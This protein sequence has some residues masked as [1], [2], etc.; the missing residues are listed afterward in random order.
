MSGPL[1]W[2]R[3]RRD[4]L[5]RDA[6][7][8]LVY[9]VGDIHGRYDLLKLLLAEVAADL[10]AAPR[11][12]RPYLIFCG[13][14]VDR[15]PSS[16]LVL[17]ALVQLQA[18]D[19][20]LVHTLKGNHEDAFLTFL[21]DPQTGVFWMPNGGDATLLAYGVHPPLPEDPPEDWTRARDALLRSMPSSHLRLLQRL[22]LMVVVGSYV[23]VHAGVRPGTPLAAQNERDLL[24]IREPFISNEGPFEKIVV[25]GHTWIDDV[26]RAFDHRIGLDTGAY[27][28]GALTAG[29][30]EGGEVRFLQ[31][32]A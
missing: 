2:L 7:D 17:E 26:P 31:A 21:D 4:G 3:R 25:H 27:R 15:G 6:G 19:D 11:S 9:A 30:F 12:L 24:W 1:G 13:D 22:E 10:R 5:R 18:R 29:R 28:T 32:R 23:F 20:F 16:H 14:Y 8:A